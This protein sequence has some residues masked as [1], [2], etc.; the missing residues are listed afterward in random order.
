MSILIHQEH[1]RIG[2]DRAG[3]RYALRFTTGT[4]TRHLLQQFRNVDRIRRGTH[5]G[6][7]FGFRNILHSQAERNILEHAHMGKE[8][9]VLKDHS[10]SALTRLQI[11]D[12]GVADQDFAA[13]GGLQARDHVERGRLPAAGRS[14]HDQELAIANVQI[15]AIDRL[16][17]AKLLDEVFQYDSCHC[18]PFNVATF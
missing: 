14:D 5:T 13:G 2:D 16:E 1:A 6:L 17:G 12:D 7:H 3:K 4:L 18:T 8:R 10:Q 11:I 15:H 9:E